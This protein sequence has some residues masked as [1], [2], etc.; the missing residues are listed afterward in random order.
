MQVAVLLAM[1]NPRAIFGYEGAVSE[2]LRPSGLQLIT[3]HPGTQDV[4]LGSEY[5]ISVPDR[6]AADQAVAILREQP[7]VEKAEIHD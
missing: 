6:A 7:G 3:R 4:R 1:P 2:A 5:F